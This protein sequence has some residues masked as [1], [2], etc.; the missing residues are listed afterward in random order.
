MTLGVRSY[1]LRDKAII[2]WGI[3]NILWLRVQRNQLWPM[4]VMLQSLPGKRLEKSMHNQNQSF[5]RKL[6]FR[7][8][9]LRWN[10]KVIHPL[11]ERSKHQAR[12]KGGTLV[13]PQAT[14]KVQPLTQWVYRI[15]IVLKHRQ[16]NLDPHQHKALGREAAVLLSSGTTTLFLISKWMH[17]T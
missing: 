11:V 2:L 16:R 13:S 8:L 3:P 1:Q 10:L 12:L 7:M 5:R 15:L 17:L 14:Q 4:A 6:C 9:M